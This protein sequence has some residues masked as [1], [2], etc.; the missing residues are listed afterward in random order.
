MQRSASFFGRTAF[1]ITLFVC[2]LLLVQTVRADDGY[3]LWLRYEPLPE[4]SLNMYRLQLQSIS[5]QGKSPTFEVIRNE[6]RLG[7]AGLLGTPIIVSDSD[8]GSVIIG[9]P[10]TSTFIRQPPKSGITL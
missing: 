2:L 3:R 7:S 8:D 1:S 4:P 5:V 6:L 10:Q 9:L